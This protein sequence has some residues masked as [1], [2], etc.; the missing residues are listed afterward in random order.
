M[1]SNLHY[2]SQ[3]GTP[4]A[5]LENIQ[6]MCASGANWIQLRLKDESFKVVL[7]TA[8]TAKEICEA[9]QVKLIINDFPEVAKKID[10]HGVH[11]GK[12]DQCVLKA[13]EVL[14]PDKIIGGTAN[15]FQDCELLV[16][17]QVNYIGLGPFRF[18][19][20]KKKLSPILGVSG[21]E[22]LLRNL[23]NKGV[24]IPVIAIGGITPQD[25]P[26]LRKAGIDGIAV[27]G[28]LTDYEQPEE[29]IQ[30]IYNQFSY[31]YYGNP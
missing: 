28:C 2:I 7:K 17:K 4:E 16:K 25:L 15:T 1:I 9:F 23:R 10:A 21:Y 27:S 13:R 22:K 14:G 26:S 29:I 24:G 20:T 6:R 12:Q 18:T 31:N 11:L 3:G 19:T 5:H 30:D 8:E